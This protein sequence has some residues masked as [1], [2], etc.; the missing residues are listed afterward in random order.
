MLAAD[1]GF[2]GGFLCNRRRS[3]RVLS[4]QFGGGFGYGERR[5]H[6]SY[7]PSGHGVCFRH[8][9]DNHRAVGDFWEGAERR[10]RAGEVDMLIDF[11]GE[12]DDVGP[13]GED[14][15]ERFQFIV[16]IYA[17]GGVRR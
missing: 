8:S 5:S 17:A 13:F 1:V 10:E 15:D 7:A 14:I 2:F 9:V 4:L 3:R 16:G 11:V 12:D 6:E